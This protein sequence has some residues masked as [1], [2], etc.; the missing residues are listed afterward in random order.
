MRIENREIDENRKLFVNRKLIY[1]YCENLIKITSQGLM[2]NKLQLRD[3]AVR[4]EKPF[5]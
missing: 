3:T 5:C 4:R 1:L 2:R